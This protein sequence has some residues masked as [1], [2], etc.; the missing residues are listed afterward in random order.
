MK[1]LSND[2]S[3]N[4]KLDIGGINM[5]SEPNRKDILLK[6]AYDILKECNRGPYV[7]NALEVTAIWDD[8]ECDGYCL[9]D[10]ISDEL[11]LMEDNH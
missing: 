1:V 4:Y 11:G 2:T 10:E 9:M 5:C 8:A 3:I 7:K 6:A